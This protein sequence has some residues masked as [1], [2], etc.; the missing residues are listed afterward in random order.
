MRTTDKE[1]PE[2][3]PKIE[4]AKE[5]VKPKRKPLADVADA[6]KNK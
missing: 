3:E 4:K 1:E 5:T 6:R 2:P